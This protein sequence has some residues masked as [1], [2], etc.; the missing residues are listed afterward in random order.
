MFRESLQ[1]RTFS[2]G[3]QSRCYCQIWVYEQACRNGDFIRRRVKPYT[4]PRFSKN[5]ALT[6]ILNTFDE[7]D[8]ETHVKNVVDI[9]EQIGNLKVLENL[10]ELWEFPTQALQFEINTLTPYIL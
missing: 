8:H 10:R 3:C 4:F 9:A 2:W 7:L 6:R 5:G 1:R